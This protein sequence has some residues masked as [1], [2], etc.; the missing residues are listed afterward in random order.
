MKSLFETALAP[1]SFWRPHYEDV[2][3][4]LDHGSF[5]FWLVAAVR[6]RRIVEL[7]THGGFSYFCFC[8]AVADL[9]LSAQCHAIDTWLG[10]EQTGFYTEAVFERVNDYNNN[11]YSAFSN[12]TRTTFKE[13]LPYFEDGTIDLL[14]IDGRHFYE[15][16]KTDFESWLPKLSSRAVVLFH[17]TNVRERGFG[18]HRFWSELCKIRPSFEF[19]HG[20]GLGLLAVGTEQS[21][22]ISS[23]LDMTNDQAAAAEIREIYS[24]L[25]SSIKFSI[26]RRVQYESKERDFASQ[27]ALLQQELTV[28]RGEF[29]E[30]RNQHSQSVANGS[31][32]AE[33]LAT[34]EAQADAQ[35]AIFTSRQVEMEEILTANRVELEELRDRHIQSVANDSAL[36]ERLATIKAQADAQEAILAH[37]QVEEIK[38][39]RLRKQYEASLGLNEELA[40][41]L[42]AIKAERTV[43]IGREAEAA[44]RVLLLEAVVAETAV[45]NRLESPAKKSSLIDRLQ[46]LGLFP[47]R[48]F[49]CKKPPE[50]R[51]LF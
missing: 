30:L 9:K 4:W 28:S 43:L 14:H 19:Y 11:Y 40:A 13:A 34:I 45:L 44:A 8:Q 41:R 37:R 15:D 5:A 38:Q 51:D 25:G 10:D 12:L 47:A 48:R 24:R 50:A 21:A 46:L 18:V 33:R 31:V 3:A 29:E 42:A 6:P 26:L 22:I 2:S 20:Y 35:K 27:L 23:F 39:Q 16:V 7:G 1:C 36:A 17:D 49:F 32:L